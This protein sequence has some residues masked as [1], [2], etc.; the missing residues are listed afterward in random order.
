MK[1]NQEERAARAWPILAAVA[2]TKMNITYAELGAQLGIHRR[3]CRYV[4]LEIQNYC[5]END[6]PPLTM[7]VVIS[8]TGLPGVGCVVHDPRTIALQR[9]EVRKF[10]WLTQDNPFG[11]AATGMTGEQLAA[12]LVGNPSN[13]GDIYRLVKARGKVQ[14]L[15]RM[16]LLRA[17][18]YQCALTELT[19]TGVLEACHIMP[20]AQCNEAERLD[21]RNGVLLNRNH[22]K[23]FDSGLITFDQNLKLV[24]SDPEEEDGPYSEIDRDLSV[25]LHGT[26]LRLPNPISLQPNT[27]YLKRSHEWYGWEF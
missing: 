22:H 18:G 1:V 11:Y 19:F 5:L 9:E 14:R 25:R 12:E 7:V 15:F 24:Y 27:E 13:A 6:W 8:K 23:L 20:W 10:P 4:L 21:V 16:A 2:A 17:Y 3:A 26:R